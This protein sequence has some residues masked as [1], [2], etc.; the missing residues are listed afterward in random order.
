MDE[1]VS[2]LLRGGPNRE[3]SRARLARP[4]RGRRAFRA[5]AVQRS[6]APRGGSL[7]LERDVTVLHVRRERRESD[8]PVGRSRPRA[9][10]QQAS[11]S[12]PSTTISGLDI[13]CCIARSDD[14]RAERGVGRPGMSCGRDCVGRAGRANARGKARAQAPS[15]V[16]FHRGAVLEACCASRS[17][18]RASSRYLGADSLDRRVT[19][20]YRE[21]TTIRGNTVR[22]E[23]EG[24]DARSFALERVP[25]LEGF[26][27]AFGALLAGDC[28]RARKDFRH[29]GERR[30]S[31][32][33]DAR[34]HAAR[35][36]RAAPRE[37]DQDLR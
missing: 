3:N 5:R 29:C 22:I 10:M 31:R 33:V 19:S 37:R 7:Q 30:R 8:V 20:P 36:A 16:A 4:T 12:P 11:R 21:T 18:C 23:R 34:A 1:S 13:R 9:S 28:C 15:S 2:R 6:S 27:T 24:Q 25:E 14:E 17:S 32:R 35:R 26:L